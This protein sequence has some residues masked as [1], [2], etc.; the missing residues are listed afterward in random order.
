MKD[1]TPNVIRVFDSCSKEY[2]SKYMDISLY[3][4]SFDLFCASIKKDRANLLELGCGPG[5][6]TKYIAEK[7]PHYTILSTDISTNMLKLARK[8]VPGAT[9]VEMDARNSAN[10]NGTFDGII[11]G[12]CLPYLTKEEAVQLIHDTSDLLESEGILYLSLMEGLYSSSAL[13]TSSSGEHELFIH[14][15]EFE[16]LDQ[17]IKAA[18]LFLLKTLRVEYVTNG[19]DVTDLILV[20][21]KQ[22]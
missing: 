11:C 8:N 7:H 10:L 20:I 4:E 6:I 17:A 14:F 2:Q 16:Y 22:V 13:T 21:K 18:G 12:F 9:F 1:Q 15:H 19:K 5:N 3:K